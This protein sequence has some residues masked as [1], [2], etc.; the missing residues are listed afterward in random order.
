MV[1]LA[2]KGSLLKFEAFP[3]AKRYFVAYSGGIDSTALLH[4]TCQIPEIKQKLCVIHINHNIQPE[5]EQ[6][7]KHC[8]SFCKWL[9]VPLVVESVYLDSSSENSCRQARLACYNKHLLKGDCLLMAHHA[10]D[11][12]ET[13]LFRL[14]RGTGLNG[15]TGMSPIQSMNHYQIFR[16]FLSVNKTELVSY[17]KAHQLTHVSDLS[18]MDNSYSRNYIRNNLIPA[19]QNYNKQAFANIITTA[20]NLRQSEELLRQFISCSN[21][22]KINQYRTTKSLSAVL[23]HWLLH[24]GQVAPSHKQLNQFAHDCLRAAVDKNPELIFNKNKLFRW[25]GQIYALRQLA[26]PQHASH[27][28]ELQPNRKVPLDH[29]HLLLTSDTTETLNVIIKHQQGFES[30]QTDLKRPPRSLKKLFQE[31]QIPPWI[32]QIIPYIYVDD[33]LVAV[34]SQFISHSFQHYL[35]QNKTQIEWLSPKFLL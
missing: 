14:L 2:N 13:I 27:S 20:E 15:L 34:G 29:G 33:K 10:D 1:P 28:I 23:Y 30:I 9:D 18:N 5:A 22:L 12:I 7:V 3:P 19:L 11:Q 32:R 31:N 6:W 26:D 8:E 16:P 25:R 21:P 4:A 24:L 35:K 17:V